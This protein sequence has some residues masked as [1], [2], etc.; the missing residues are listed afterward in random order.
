M[1][2]RILSYNIHGAKGTDGVRDYGRIGEYLKKEKIDVV[3]IQELE[4]RT[5]K[6]NTKKELADLCTDHFT[7]YVT[8][9]TIMDQE[10][11]YGN[12]VLSKFPITSHNLIDIT[13]LGF[14]PRNILEA[15]VLTPQGPLH[16]VTTH[17][18]LNGVERGHQ[19][20]KLHRLLRNKSEVPLIVGGD[21]NQWHVYS[22]AFKKLNQNLT[23]Q[24]TG[25]TFP[26]RYPC[27]RLDRMWC[28]PPGLVTSTKVIK[29]KCTRIFSDHYPLLAEIS[30]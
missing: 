30:F 29:N 22:K 25:P 20:G 23:L 21:I 24:N 15:F 12:A 2:Y 27:L 3:L 1:K 26:T 7:H 18:G 28:R 4:T 19:L 14:E 6:S 16:V 8:A 13:T 9:P 11:W 5:Q 10:G 17:K